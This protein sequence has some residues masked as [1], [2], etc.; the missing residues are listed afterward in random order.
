MAQHHPTDEERRQIRALWSVGTRSTTDIVLVLTGRVKRRVRAEMVRLRSLVGSLAQPLPTGG[1]TPI[2]RSEP[3]AEQPPVAPTSALDAGTALLLRFLE[4]VREDFGRVP[5]AQLAGPALRIMR[6][7]MSTD[8]RPTVVGRM[9]LGRRFLAVQGLARMLESGAPAELGSTH[10]LAS[11]LLVLLGPLPDARPIPGL[12]AA[13]ST[14]LARQLENGA[15]ADLE[16]TALACRALRLLGPAGGKR[17]ESAL[18]RAA[19]WVESIQA[20]DGAFRA[21][22][23]PTTPATAAWALETLLEAGRDPSA[24]S[25]ARGISWLNSRVGGPERDDPGRYL[26]D[27]GPALRVLMRAGPPSEIERRSEVVTS[28]LRQVL[29]TADAVTPPWRPCAE[30]LETLGMACRLKQSRQAAEASVA[31]DPDWVFCTESL[32]RVSR[33]FSQPIALLP[34]RLR[35][36]VTV[37]YLLCRIADTVEDHAAIGADRRD[38][39]LRMLIDVLEDRTS[40]ASFTAALADIAGDGPELELVRALPRVMRVFRSE[41]RTAQ[42]STVR[43]V[44]EMSRGMTLYSHRRRAPGSLTVLRTIGDLERYCYFVAGTVGFLL[45]DLFVEEM[46][47]AATHEIEL[48]LRARAESFGIGLQLVNVLKDVTDD[49]ARGWSYLPE[50]LLAA[51]QLTAEDIADPVVRA[52]AH[53]AVAPVFALARHHLDQGLEYTLAIPTR[54]S[55]IRLFCLLPLWMAASTL[56]L[57]AGNDAMFVPNQ[58]VK[59]S[60]DQVRALIEEC[61]EC[62]GDNEKLRERYAALWQDDAVRCSAG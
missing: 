32:S 27:F 61:L 20:E 11:L 48:G 56:R 31:A 10:N 42:E 2:P 26:V 15:F 21:G 19:R 5:D 38:P 52:R 3:N 29:R 16:T 28:A 54:F 50:T 47:G 36:A 62:Q 35:M 18:E 43:W 17:V 41:S 39:L 57:A 40:P 6:A 4:R 45:T 13:V 12:D 59:I 51:Q 44:S 9:L 33:T 22:A 1:A 24:P 55:G 34:E 49:L 53:R 58:P 60:R 8:M 37:G 23:L 25:V 30:A 46:G 14:L 7:L